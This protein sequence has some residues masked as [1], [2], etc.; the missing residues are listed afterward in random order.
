MFFVFLQ[1]HRKMQRNFLSENSESRIV[2]G[3]DATR[4]YAYQVSL[5]GTYWNGE[6]YAWYHFC[7]GSIITERH[8]LSAGFISF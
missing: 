6:A 3:K 5:Q 2:G 4:P 1:T 7:G 8:I